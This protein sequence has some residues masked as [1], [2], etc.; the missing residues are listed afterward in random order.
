M[1]IAAV[2]RLS[3]ARAGWHGKPALPA[4]EDLCI[5]S[6]RSREGPGYVVLPIEAFFVGERPQMT[7]H[8]AQT[9]TRPYKPQNALPVFRWIA[10]K[11]GD[12]QLRPAL[13]GCFGRRHGPEQV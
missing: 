6:H 13:A 8:G 2:H 10:V 12:P 5:G 3:P 11:R 4:V 1:L 7:D 9:Q